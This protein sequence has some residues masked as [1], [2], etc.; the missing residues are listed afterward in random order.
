MYHR[1]HSLIVRATISVF[2]LLRIFCND[3]LAVL[4]PMSVV[5]QKVGRQ[6]RIQGFELFESLN[7]IHPTKRR[8]ERDKRSKF[9][10]LVNPTAKFSTI[11]VI[12]AIMVSLKASS[13]P[14]F[15]GCFFLCQKGRLKKQKHKTTRNSVFNA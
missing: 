5:L 14:L 15:S 11:S 9:L 6:S 7:F 8:S 12:D 1:P 3:R 4:N 10:L 13:Q 2:G